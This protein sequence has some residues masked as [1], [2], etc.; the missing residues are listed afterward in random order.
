MTHITEKW[1]VTIEVKQLLARFIFIGDLT[2]KKI[3]FKAKQL[4]FLTFYGQFLACHYVLQN[5][6]FLIEWFNKPTRKRFS[7]LL[8]FWFMRS[9]R[10]KFIASSITIY[11]NCNFFRCQRL[12]NLT[13]NNLLLKEI[14]MFIIN[15]QRDLLSSRVLALPR[16][17]FFALAQWWTT[18]KVLLWRIESSLKCS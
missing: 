1:S 3:F 7:N 8:K 11:S 6:T 14:K 17:L 18:T 16:R 10:G 13:I 9:E 2:K 12:V 5:T 15:K 4:F